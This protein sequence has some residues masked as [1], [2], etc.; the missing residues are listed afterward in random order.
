MSPRNKLLMTAVVWWSRHVPHCC[1][2]SPVQAATLPPEATYLGFGKPSWDVA[3]E[4]SGAPREP[5]CLS[6]RGSA[7]HD[8][9]YHLPFPSPCRG[10]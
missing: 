8:P 1:S 2:I 7:W 6:V 5:G 3:R 9:K 4:S 10:S